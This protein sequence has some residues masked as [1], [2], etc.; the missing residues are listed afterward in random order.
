MENENKKPD[1]VDFY[2]YD[3][4]MARAERH[5]NRW[6]IAFFVTFV[7]LV[8]SNICWILYESQFVDEVTV[9]QDVT[10]GNNNYV[11]NNGDIINGSSEANGN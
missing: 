6:M 8:I 3:E 4:A 9:T 5:V 2:L 11:G 1:K 7:V 10:D